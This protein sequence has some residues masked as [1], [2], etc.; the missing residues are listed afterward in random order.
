MLRRPTNRQTR[1]QVELSDRISLELFGVLYCRPK[2]IG[3]EH[4][5]NFWELIFV[6]GDRYFFKYEGKQHLCIPNE[7]YLIEPNKKHQFINDN[8]I[9]TN[10]VYL[11]FD[12]AFYPRRRLRQGIPLQLIH[13]PEKTV[14]STHFRE[15][16]TL[17]LR[18]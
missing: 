13:V 14:L 17:P 11:G 3:E 6:T 12:F 7:L 1:I 15:I 4:T 18:G 10:L 5:H 8:S 9:D 2:W 16:S